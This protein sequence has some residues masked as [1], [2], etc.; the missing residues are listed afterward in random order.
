MSV[1]L[2]AE[3]RERGGV[4]AV[5]EFLGKAMREVTVRASE[6]GYFV[7][8]LT[9]GMVAALNLTGGVQHRDSPLDENG[10]HGIV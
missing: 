6:S 2:Q 4:A 8:A 10:P 7:V 3:G 5:A 9:A 1:E